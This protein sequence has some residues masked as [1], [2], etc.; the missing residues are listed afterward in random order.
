MF[1]RLLKLI[2]FFLVISFAFILGVK[3]SDS[4]HATT[5]RS[6]TNAVQSQDGFNVRRVQDERSDESVNIRYQDRSNEKP[7]A[8]VNNLPPREEEIQV[9]QPQPQPQNTSNVEPVESVET[10][11]ITESTEPAESAE[12]SDVDVVIESNGAEIEEVQTGGGDVVEEVI[13]TTNE[14]E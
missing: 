13:S 1:I 12:S 6:V 7:K 11:E 4:F 3:F 8:Q 2:L 9:P 14:A 10:V 5:A